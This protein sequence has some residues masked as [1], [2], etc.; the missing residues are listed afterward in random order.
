M[1]EPAHTL[2]SFDDFPDSKLDEF[3]DELA[4]NARI[5][6][7]P[8]TDDVA[9]TS[10]KVATSSKSPKLRV[11]KPAIATSSKNEVTDPKTKKLPRKVAGCYWANNGAGWLLHRSRRDD[12]NRNPRIGH[13]SQ[14]RYDELKREHKGTQLTAALTE[15]AKAKATEKG[16]QLD[17]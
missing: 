10:K 3:S 12:R 7:P 5:K 14:A 9:T 1:V 4:T 6:W 16:I 15:W 2:I 13:L 17:L 11:T 8:V